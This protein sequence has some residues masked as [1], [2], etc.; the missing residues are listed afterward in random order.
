MKKSRV[1]RKDSVN[2]A[3]KFFQVIA[4]DNEQ[5]NRIYKLRKKKTESEYEELG[6]YFS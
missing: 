1:Y 6:E 2:L 3:G 4:K 5:T